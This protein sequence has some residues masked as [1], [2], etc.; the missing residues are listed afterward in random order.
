MTGRERLTTVLNGG[1]VDRVPVVPFIYNNFINEFYHSKDADSVQK[2]LELYEYF[3]CDIILRTCNQYAYM[4]ELA[5]DAKNW[6]VTEARE[7]DDKEWAVTTTIKTPEKELTQKKR[8]SYVTANEAVEAVVDFYIKDEDD[9]RQFVKYQPPL[10]RYDCSI[11]KKAREFLGDKGLAAPWVEGAFNFASFFRKMDELIIDAYENPKLYNGMIK[12]FSDRSLEVIRQFAE[13]GADIVCSSGNVANAI[14]AG[15][16]FFKEHVL[17]HE[18]EFTRRAKAYGPYFLY[19]NCGYA[20]PLLAMYSDIKMNIYESL[21]AAPYGDTVLEDALSKID[22][23]I[24]LLGNIDQIEFLIKA[25]P[26]EVRKEVKRV[27]NL[28]KKRGNF[29]LGTSDY[30]SEGTP[31]ENIEAFVEAGLEYGRY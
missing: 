8:Y 27:L 23:K 14:F 9:F 22:R 28:A 13:A 11:I 18:I 24:T 16:H 29:I 30:L 19:H 2:G 6:R 31:H 17:P 3:G 12:Y 15:P 25:S 26:E 4:S 10:P 7:G 1:K 5:T 21:S 20:A